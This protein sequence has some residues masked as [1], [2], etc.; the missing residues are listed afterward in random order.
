MKYV[1][2][3][4]SLTL[5]H[6]EFVNRSLYDSTVKVRLCDIERSVSLGP[7]ISNMQHCSIQRS[8]YNRII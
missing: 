3:I 5:P 8:R 2:A 7:P 1:Y 6:N 4:S